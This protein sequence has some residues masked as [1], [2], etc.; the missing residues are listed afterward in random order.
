MAENFRENGRSQPTAARALVGSGKAV[1]RPGDGADI[2]S[3]KDDILMRHSFEIY[4]G[5][6]NFYFHN[7]RILD[8]IAAP[9]ATVIGILVVETGNRG[10]HLGKDC[11]QPGYGSVAAELGGGSP[12]RRER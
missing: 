8:G 9:A 12:S 2:R 7:G 1:P 10:V 5:L 4:R 6:A 3:S 11:R